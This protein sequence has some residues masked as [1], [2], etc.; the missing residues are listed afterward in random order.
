MT[1]SRL[2]RDGGGLIGCVGVERGR[3]EAVIIRYA[4]I[5]LG[6]SIDPLIDNTIPTYRLVARMRSSNRVCTLECSLVHE[7]LIEPSVFLGH[8]YLTI[9]AHLIL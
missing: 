7:V 9:C 3:T 6:L 8:A 1:S 2:S 4:F 5:H